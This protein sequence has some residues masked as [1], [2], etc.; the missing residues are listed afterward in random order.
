MPLLGIGKKQEPAQAPAEVPDELPD[1]P[2]AEAPAE[3][4]A[5][6][7]VPD[8]LPPA[9]LSPVEDLAPDELPPVGDMGVADQGAT[10]GIDRRL[11]FSNLLQKLNQ[12][13]I[14]STKLTSPSVN[15]LSDMKRHWKLQKKEAEK[16]EMNRMLADSL[17]PLQR[18][19]NEWVAL[20]EDI[21]LKKKQLHDKEEEIRKLAEEAKALALKAERFQKT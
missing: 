8:E 15:M 10:Q 9:E 18:L 12:E 6:M 3:A 1:L 2:Q 20:Q 13:G 11:Y 16:D 5:D 17:T 14:K 21:E 7:D 4:G 19:E